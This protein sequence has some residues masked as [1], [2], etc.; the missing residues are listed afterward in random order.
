[1][2]SARAIAG[3]LALFLLTAAPPALA[4]GFVSASDDLPLAPGL[5][6]L[7]GRGHSFDSPAGRLIE[8]YA[9]GNVKAAEVL[10]FYA[11]TLPQ[12]GWI[13]ESDTRYRRESERLEFEPRSQGRGLLLRIAITPE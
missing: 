1:M 13:R 7:A 12:L 6:E 11:A 8:A 10:A 3:I 2:Q 4:Q 9:S 5:V